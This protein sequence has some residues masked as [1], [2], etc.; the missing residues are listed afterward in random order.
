MCPVSLMDVTTRT[1]LSWYLLQAGRPKRWKK[2]PKST[3]C[4]I[5]L[6]MLQKILF[7]FEAMIWKST[8]PVAKLWCSCFI[9]F[10]GNCFLGGVTFVACPPVISAFSSVLFVGKPT[11]T[12]LV[13]SC[14]FCKLVHFSDDS[15]FFDGLSLTIFQHFAGLT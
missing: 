12:S 14:L 1:F 5:S 6:A 7:Q 2:N 15:L 11:Q 9:M 13:R 10:E 8:L 4:I 3:I